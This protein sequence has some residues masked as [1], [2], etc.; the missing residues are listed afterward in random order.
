MKKVKLHLKWQNFWISGLRIIYVKSRKFLSRNTVMHFIRKL[1]A[2]SRS[3]ILAV[4]DSPAIRYQI[5]SLL[6]RIGATLPLYR[7]L[8]LLSVHLLVALVLPVMTCRRHPPDPHFR[9]IFSHLATKKKTIGLQ[10][11]TWRMFLQNAVPLTTESIF[12]GQFSKIL[13]AFLQALEPLSA[14]MLLLISNVQYNR[15]IFL[16]DS[17]SARCQGVNMCHLVTTNTWSKSLKDSPFQK[18]NWPTISLHR[19]L[20]LIILLP[21]SYMQSIIASI[22]TYDCLILLH[23]LIRTSLL[24]FIILPPPWPHVSG[25]FSS[26]S[27]TSSIT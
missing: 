25:I 8:P 5:C 18:L 9:M 16:L 23:H 26:C 21:I 14:E 1:L 2:S 24:S 7:V 17:A 22:Q 6:L 27:P 19:F 12:P 10:M 3:S 4:A 15:I 20:Y 11:S 13:M